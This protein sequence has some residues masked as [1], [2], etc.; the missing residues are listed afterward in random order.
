MTR[1]PAD[2]SAAR[3]ADASSKRKW[4][5]PMPLATNT[6]GTLQELAM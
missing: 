3:A 5:R 6:P 4:A 1:M 2:S